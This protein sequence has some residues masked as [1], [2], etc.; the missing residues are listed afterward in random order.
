LVKGISSSINVI[1]AVNAVN[2]RFN[3][4]VLFGGQYPVHS[5]HFSWCFASCSH[6]MWCEW[7]CSSLEFPRFQYG[8]WWAKKASPRKTSKTNLL[9]QQVKVSWVLKCLQSFAAYPSWRVW[10]TK[11]IFSRNAWKLHQQETKAMEC[12]AREAF[13]TRSSRMATYQNG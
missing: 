3:H 9:F 4:D 13:C 1:L 6:A 7:Q 2:W 10:K 11:I 12:R 5:V 8:L